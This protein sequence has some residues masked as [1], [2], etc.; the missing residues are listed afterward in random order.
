MQ[1][2]N[3]TNNPFIKSSIQNKDSDSM[4]NK[5]QFSIFKFMTNP[6]TLKI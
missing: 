1:S 3:N 5:F 2:L 4:D 6:E